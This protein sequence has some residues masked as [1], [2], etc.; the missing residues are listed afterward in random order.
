MSE[1]A[2]LLARLRRLEDREAVRDCVARAARG[3]DRHDRDILRAAFHDDAVVNVTEFVGRLPEFIEW[4]H[5]GHSAMYGGHTHNITCQTVE[6]DGDTAHAE[7]YVVMVLRHKDGKTV[8]VAGGRYVD[9]L[10]R[11]GGAWRIA[12][13]RLAPDWR[14]TADG[15][16]FVPG[17]PGVPYGSWDRG[18]ISYQRPLTLPPE[19]QAKLDAKSGGG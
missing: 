10:E 14:F 9:R 8:T 4:S 12:L 16:A 7:S 5:A 1:D 2:D 6:L 18:D 3:L 17:R 19:L 15:S 11:R 13:R